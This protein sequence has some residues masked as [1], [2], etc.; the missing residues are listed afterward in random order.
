MDITNNYTPVV[1]VKDYGYT[2][3]V[4]F[5]VFAYFINLI[6]YSNKL[7]YNRDNK[8]FSR[9]IIKSVKFIQFPKHIA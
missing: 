2:L 9:L 8:L 5:P 6:Q 4:T 3:S 7:V 1:L